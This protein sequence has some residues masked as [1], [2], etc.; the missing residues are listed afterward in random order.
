MS[1]SYDII[2]IG[3]GICGTFLSYYLYKA[4]VK[5]LV[6]DSPQP[7][8]ASKV[9]SGIINPVTGRQVVTTWLADELIPFAGVAYGAIGTAIGATVAHQ[10]NIIVFPPSQQMSDAY[11]K[12]MAEDNSYIK[13]ASEHTYGAFKDVF[14][15]YYGIAVIE[16][17][18]HIDLHT[19]L[20]GWR[21]VLQQSNM[22][23]Q[24]KFDESHLT[25]TTDGVQYKNIKA[26]KI[27]F[28]NGVD[29]F[30]QPWFKSLPFVF[31]KGEALI[32][33]IP[34]LQPN[35][36]YKIGN[37]TIVPWY[38]GLWWVG[39]SYENEFTNALP[40]DSFKAKKTYELQQYLKLPFTIV[41]HFA[42]LRPAVAIERRPF[43]GFHPA[44]P[45]IGILNG[46]GTKGCSLAPY[47]AQQLADSLINGGIINPLADVKR[48]ARVLGL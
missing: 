19:L 27:I 20:H 10:K 12:R 21:Q 46:M 39:S 29:T 7:F 37:S 13:Q 40:T 34:Q 45:A 35:N 42:S 4:G 26:S 43:V 2:V 47:F 32:A 24:E 8:S 3:Q 41:D 30:S 22:L 36:I 1:N 15:S 38:D 23:L 33:D 25:I 16:P 28:C 31:N 14:F 17:V 44:Y 48:F 9:A 6:I 5:V 18:W 11:A